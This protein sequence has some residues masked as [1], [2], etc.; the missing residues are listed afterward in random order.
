MNGAAGWQRVRDWWR[1]QS[2]TDRTVLAAQALLVAGALLF[3]FWASAG[4]SAT[5]RPDFKTVASTWAPPVWLLV[6]ASLTLTSLVASPWY[7]LVG[8]LAYLVVMHGLPSE[9]P[10]FQWVHEVWLPEITLTLAV[11]GW[12]GWLVRKG[13]RDVFPNHPLAW[14]MLGLV[15]AACLSSVV[16]AFTLANVE[17]SLRRS[18]RRFL[19]GLALFAIAVHALTTPRQLKALAGTLAVVLCVRTWVYPEL[20]A[21]NND[22]GYLIP[23]ALPLVG[24]GVAWARGYEGKAVWLA[25]LA[26]LGYVLV[27]TENRG[28]LVA[29]VGAGLAF[30]L[31]LTPRRAVA[32][33]AGLV[34]VVGLVFGLHQGIRQRFV[35]VWQGGPEMESGRERLAIWSG[36]GRISRDHPLLGVGPGRSSSLLG[37]YLPNW[38]NYDPHNNLVALLAETGAVGLTLYCGLFAG[39]LWVA[40]R[41]TRRG[42]NNW[43]RQFGQA[44]FPALVAYL[45]AG[46]FLA[47]EGLE[48]AYLLCGAC[49]AWDRMALLWREQTALAGGTPTPAPT[50]PARSPSRAPWPDARHLLGAAVLF[51][52]FAVYGSWV[53]LNYHAKDFAVAVEQ[54][55]QTPFL[56]LDINRRADWVANGLVFIPLGFFWL[57]FVSV[58]RDRRVAWVGALGIAPTLAALAVAIEFSQL[59]FVGRTVSQNDIVAEALGSVVGLA[60]WLGWGQRAVEWVRGY[61]RTRDRNRQID[62]LLQAYLVGLI[63]ASLMPFDL[64]LSAGELYRKFQGGMVNLIPFAATHDDWRMAIFSTAGNVLLCI[65]VGALAARLWCRKGETVRA[66]WPAVG[67]GVAIRAGIECAQ[68]FVYSRFVDVTDVLLGAV[69]V[70]AGVYLAHRLARRP[71]AVEK[72][73]HPSHVRRTRWI[74]SAA[75]LGYTVLLFCT[76]WYPY[77]FTS[78]RAVIAGRFHDMIHRPPFAALYGGAEFNAFVQ[79]LFRIGMFAP[80]GALCA[81]AVLS[82]TRNPRTRRWLGV[83]LFLACAALAA[84]LEFGQVLLPSRIADLTELLFYAGGAGLGMWLTYRLVGPAPRPAS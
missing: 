29:A 8:C 15:V 77:D 6:A 72:L 14:L 2:P 71:V 37:E 64:T 36:M 32:A 21:R 54:F 45:V 1:G 63:L 66:F 11:T 26:Y 31:T 62:W 74:L 73:F 28:G 41:L 67:I 33:L 75:I 48:V 39:A 7:P 42:N 43:T 78:D 57:G 19:A 79:M 24:L 25:A 12:A 70:V 84:G 3:L 13:R 23:V 17:T 53:P 44:V 20:T 52:L 27:W 4:Y 80:L 50:T 9:G 83:L 34:L 65:P 38:A 76:F 40:W 51:T 82:A 35:D 47:R 49:V 30:T 55:K 5:G 60:V 16:S 22:L 59:W 68:L 18:P 81:L 10:A 69:G 58:D 61:A 56:D 46:L